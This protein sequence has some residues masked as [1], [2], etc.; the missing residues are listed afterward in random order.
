EGWLDEGLARYATELAARS[1]LPGDTTTYHQYLTF[2]DLYNAYQYLLDPGDSYLL[3]VADNGTLAESG[4]SWL[5]VRFLVDQYSTSIPNLPA[6]LV[7]S[8]YIGPMNITARTNGGSFQTIVTD[9]AMA[10]YVSHLQVPGFTAPAAL[11]YTSWSFRATYDTLHRSS[12]ALTASRYP[13]DYPLVPAVAPGDQVYLSGKLR[14]GSGYYV[15]AMQG[16]AAQAFALS[17][18]LDGTNALDTTVVPRLDV[19][20]IR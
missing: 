1:F 7:Q 9:W 13:L 19:V 4:A 18:T 8:P 5:F 20:R 12:N 3:L 2:G 14:S 6:L 15:R 10:N 16:P 11:K 17:F